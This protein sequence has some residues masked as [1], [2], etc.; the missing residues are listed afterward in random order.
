MKAHGQKKNGGQAGNK[1][2]IDIHAQ[3]GQALTSSLSGTPALPRPHTP[4]SHHP[5]PPKPRPLSDSEAA[6]GPLEFPPANA[7]ATLSSS[8]AEDKLTPQCLT[9]QLTHAQ[10]AAAVH[11]ASPLLSS[12]IMRGHAVSKQG[13]FEAFAMSASC[14]LASAIGMPSGSSS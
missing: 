10:S 5:P 6:G 8:N 11:A 7:C 1:G 9:R 13:M 2:V 4:L 14:L 12:T 3:E